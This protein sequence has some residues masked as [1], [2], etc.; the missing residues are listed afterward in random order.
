MDD[1]FAQLPR[2][3]AERSRTLD[4]AGVPALLAH[5]DWQ[6]PAPVMLWMH[7]RTAHKEL[8]PGRYQRWLRAGIACVA[9]DLPGHGA[10]YEVD[11]HHPRRTM[12]VLEGVLGE[13]NAVL[14]ALRTIDDAHALDLSRLG[15]GGM[16]AGGMAALR[17]LCEPHTFRCAAVE[18]TTGWLEGLYF[19]EDGRGGPWDVEHAR[20]R[21]RAMDPMRHLAG[22]AP[23]PLLALHSEA[24]Q[25]V[26][27]PTQ[28]AFLDRLRGH[29]ADR[30]ADP[31][32]IQV[33]TW[34]STGAPS[35][36]AGFGSVSNDAKNAQTE[37]LARW[38]A[39]GSIS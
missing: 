21:V 24:D 39:P 25:I 36:H 37:F 10:R 8:D 3:L 33:R 12:D 11:C 7:G 32:L 17:R 20:D 31:S 4:L 13:I 15:I 1:R 9:I 27:W 5:P 35:E 6:D 16:S 26:P 34:A 30:G 2:S 23:L 22:F 18:G 19:P 14:E 29:Y 38:L 28:R